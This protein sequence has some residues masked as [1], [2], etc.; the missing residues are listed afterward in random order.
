VLVVLER[1][2]G[3]ALDR[4]GPGAI[5]AI[6]ATSLAVSAPLSLAPLENCQYA[7]I[8]PSNGARAYVSCTGLRALTPDQRRPSAGIAEIALDAT[9]E[10]ML[11]GM[12]RASASDL[13]VGGSVIALGARRVLAIATESTTADP[14][15]SDHVVEIDVAMGTTRDVAR[16]VSGF[17]LGIGVL[18]GNIALVPDAEA[19]TIL[20]FDLGD[21]V[22]LRDS[23]P[24]DDCLDLPP[25]QIGSLSR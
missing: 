17:Q 1:L 16:S 18:S 24:I 21:D 11:T 4:A 6:D 7:S 13:V 3:R 22:T 19:S 20:R 2:G 10:L 5:V 14:S 12:A 25:R 9:G 23:I 8:D 15:R